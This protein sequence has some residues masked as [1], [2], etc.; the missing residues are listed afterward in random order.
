MKKIKTMTIFGTRP[1][2]IKLA[3]VIDGLKQS[4]N[5]ESVLV[6]TGQHREML[7]QA[8][9]QFGITPDYNLGIMQPG[10]AVA[11]VTVDSLRGVEEIISGEKPDLVLVQGDTTSAF[12]GSLAAFYQ[13]VEIGHVEAGLRTY[14]KYRPFPEEINRSLITQLSDIHFVPTPTAWECLRRE[15]IPD[16]CIFITGNTVIDSLFHVIKPDYKFANQTLRKI[17]D[18]CRLLVVTAHRRENFGRPLKEICAGVL[19][20][21][22]RFPD[23][24]VV[25]SVH[26]NPKVNLP[27]RGMLGAAPRIHLVEP[28]D[29]ADMANLL[30]RSYLVLTD[31]GGLQEEAPALAKPVL[32][33]RD[34]TERPEAVQAGMAKLIGTSSKA[35]VSNTSKLL[36][37]AG[38]YSVMSQGLSPFGD[39]KAAGRIINAIEFLHKM[40][41]K[42][43]S[44]FLSIMPKPVTDDG[45]I[46][47][48]PMSN[49]LFYM[50]LD[51]MIEKAR[52]E[53]QTV[54][55]A[56]F[57]F[58]LGDRDQ[59]TRAVRAIT[60]G[61]RETDT[62]TAVEGI[63][64][65]RL[66]L[67]LPGAGKQEAKIAV[68]RLQGHLAKSFGGRRAGDRT[69]GGL[70]AD[71]IDN[72]ERQLKIEIKTFGSGK[73][74]G[75]DASGQLRAGRKNT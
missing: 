26:S 12:A 53:R 59:F 5:F 35:I 70:R 54:S 64:G 65:K 73:E 51:E 25:F 6:T 18:D 3:P 46:D 49:D 15:G 29:Y 43:P 71:L 75:Q 27:V 42:R 17:G 74:T 1:E 21:T 4:P 20:I 72:L 13:K 31:S 68:Q 8:L 36:S 40:R 66:V 47:D 23:V 52:Q 56:T 30:S 44:P 7:G 22:Q 37:D 38:S 9:D 10:Q 45:V 11:D 2:A 24:V 34:R 28:L 41:P 50:Q 69:L 60:R 16:S 19:E 67:V 33:L 63:E 32:V 48:R 58:S 57:D 61:L 39:G 55:I 62:A 14:D